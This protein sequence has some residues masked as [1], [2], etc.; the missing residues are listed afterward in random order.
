MPQDVEMF[1]HNQEKDLD[2]LLTTKP[3]ETLRKTTL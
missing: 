2:G 1:I 3:E